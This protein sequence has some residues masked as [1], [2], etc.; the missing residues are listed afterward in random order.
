M[1]Q[2][3]YLPGGTRT[4]GFAYNNNHQVTDIT[5]ASGRVDRLRYNA[6]TRLETDERMIFFLP[7]LNRTIA[8]QSNPV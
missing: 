4:T 8:I 1:F 6:A 2:A 5:H 7:M 3:Q